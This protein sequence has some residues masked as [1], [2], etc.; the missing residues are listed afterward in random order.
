MM[1]MTET[2]RDNEHNE[3]AMVHC[4]KTR[5]ACRVVIVVIVQRLARR[6]D[7]RRQ[8]RQGQ[9]GWIRRRQND[10]RQGEDDC[11]NDRGYIGDAN[12][13]THNNT[14]TIT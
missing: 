4:R 14:R 5:L 10:H 9:A 11:D 6:A 3:D 12:A 8:P 13:Y 7:H 1:P 2:S